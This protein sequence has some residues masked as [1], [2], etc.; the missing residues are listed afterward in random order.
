[1]SGNFTL[2]NIFK[3]HPGTSMCK[4]LFHCI[5]LIYMDNLIIHSSIGG[6]M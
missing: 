2:H 6:H 3:V 1:M 4:N 5:N